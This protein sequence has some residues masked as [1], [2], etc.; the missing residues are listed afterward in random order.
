MYQLVSAIVKPLGGDGRWSEIDIGPLPM[1]TL[2]ALYKSVIATL[3]NSLLD[4]HVSFDIEPLRSVWGAS[5]MTF[6]N[7]LIA[8]GNLTLTTTDEL[9]VI[10]TRYAH[11]A[12]AF[13]ARY[14]ITPMHP[15]AAPT[16]TVPE[17]EKTWLWMTRPNTDYAAFYKNCLVNVNGMYHLTDHDPNGIYV[18]DGMKSVRLSGRNQCSILNFENIGELTFIPITPEM[19]YKQKPEQVLRHNC[20]IDTGVD[21]ID[22]T[23]FLVLGGYL[24]LTDPKTFYRVGNAE[25]AIDFMNFPLLERYYESFNLIDL[26]PLGLDST[27][28]NPTQVSIDDLYSDAVLTKYL[29]LSQSFFIV[30]DNT[31][32]F[33]EVQPLRQMATPNTYISTVDPIYPLLI[34]SGRHEPFAYRKEWGQYAVTVRNGQKGSKL[35]NT[36][37]TMD[38]HSVSDSNEPFLGYRNSHAAFLKIGTDL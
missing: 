1:S 26:S 14:A 22:K 25:F 24:H 17:E 19:V 7:F 27:T 35:F 36:I 33:T 15:T 31:D 28:A 32:V 34:G 29:T 37:K 18:I 5:S 23:V 11:F 12:D 3:S 21:L 10:Q 16:A 20:Y 9:L 38:T 2:F 4:H 6:S 30:V 8:N 13:H